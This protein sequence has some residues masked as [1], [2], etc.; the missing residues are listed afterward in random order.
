MKADTLSVARFV[1]S[2]ACAILVTLSI[3]CM[4]APA[5][6]H[7][8]HEVSAF[9]VVFLDQQSLQDTYARLYRSA[10]VHFDRDAAGSN[11]RTIRGFF[12]P[13]TRTLY[14]SKMDFE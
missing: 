8:S 4:A 9:K 2:M 7:E 10:A 14:C 13:A 6:Y 5:R 3:G 12:D 1:R 11:V